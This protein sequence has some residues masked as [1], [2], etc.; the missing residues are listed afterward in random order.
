MKSDVM[1]IY[2]ILVEVIHRSGKEICYSDLD[3]AFER[4]EDINIH[5]GCTQLCIEPT[6]KDWVLKL[7]YYYM[8][9][10]NACQDAANNYKKAI[11]MGIADILLPTRKISSIRYAKHESLPIYYQPKIYCTLA[12]YISR[13]YT[14][15]YDEVDELENDENQSKLIGNLLDKFYDN[16]FKIRW[17]WA[18]DAINHYGITFMEKVAEW[19][20]ECCVNDLHGGNVGYDEY[21]KPII[22]D[23]A[24]YFG[25]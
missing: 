13:N 19:T 8:T 2:E 24:G 4:Y 6:S 14:Q 3:E 18:R 1:T 7:P 16:G 12:D 5:S 23:Y 21:G 20:H 25:W 17:V 9:D 10:A 22:F 11:E 15:Y